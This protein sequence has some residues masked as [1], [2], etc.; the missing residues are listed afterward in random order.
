MNQAIARLRSPVDR[1]EANTSSSMSSSRPAKA[2]S[3]VT[4]RSSWSARVSPA[5]SDVVTIAPA[6]TIGLD[7]PTA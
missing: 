2:D 4:T 5:T 3:P 6:L 1:S 7:A